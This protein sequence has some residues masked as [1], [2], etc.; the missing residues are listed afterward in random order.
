MKD[1]QYNGQMKNDQKNNNGSTKHYIESLILGTGTKH[2]INKHSMVN[3]KIIVNVS[4]FIDIVSNFCGT[5][6]WAT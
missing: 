1:T 2:Y 4:H 5:K 6:D 3:S